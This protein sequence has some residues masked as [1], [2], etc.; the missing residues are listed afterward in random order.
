MF[1]IIRIGAANQTVNSRRSLYQ[2]AFMTQTRETKDFK[3]F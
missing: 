3:E 1:D 2:R